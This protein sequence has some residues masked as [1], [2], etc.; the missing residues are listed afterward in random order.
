[1]GNEFAQGREWNYQESLDWYLLED[2]FGGGWHKGVQDFVRDLNRTYQQQAALYELDN[3]PAGFEWL[4][5]D[6]ATNSVFVFERR[7]RQGEPIIVVSNFTPV[8]RHAYR[9]GVNIAGEYEEIINSDA[10]VYKGSNVANVGK[11][12]TEEIES[13]GK[14]YSL[15]LV[16][17]PL[18]TVYLKLKKAKKNVAKKRTTV[19]KRQGKTQ[20]QRQI[21]S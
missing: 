10:G 18:A 5:A 21:A 19:K 13:H 16:I 20:L 14:T 2:E 8:P 15:S 1:M 6:D 17:P 7:S 11:L 3:D 4:V 9:F 12:V